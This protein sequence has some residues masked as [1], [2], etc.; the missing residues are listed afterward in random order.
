MAVPWII[1]TVTAPLGTPR[2]NAFRVA[3]MAR[4]PGQVV[5][6]G[7][8]SCRRQTIGPYWSAHAWGNADDIHPISTGVGDK[9]VAWANANKGPFGIDY[10][11]W[12]GAAGHFPGHFHVQF[13]P[14]LEDGGAAPPCAGGPAVTISASGTVT[15][16]VLT[17]VATSGGGKQC[18]PGYVPGKNTLSGLC[19]PGAGAVGLKPTQ[20]YIDT[21][22]DAPGSLVSF[23]TGDLLGKLPAYLKV[24]AGGVVM[25]AGLAAVV[26]SATGAPMPGLAGT[27]QQVA[28]KVNEPRRQATMQARAR[29]R[30]QG[31][32]EGILRAREGAA[33][34]DAEKYAGA[35]PPEP[36]ARERRSGNIRSTSRVRAA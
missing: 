26:V 30:S 9:A 12:R 2:A 14:N 10:I 28:G 25:L 16:K 11:L 21:L 32:E 31:R 23:L 22:K 3:V 15:G 35:E 18:P 7:T 1:T 20:A 6:W 34:E 8:Y 13:L 36:S 24:A 33:R 29:A 17:S 19:V 5:S 27:V 4:F